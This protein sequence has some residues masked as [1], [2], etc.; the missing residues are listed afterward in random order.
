MP[1]HF[2]TENI[3]FKLPNPQ[4]IRRWISAVVEKEQ[5]KYNE[6]AYIFCDDAYLYTLNVDY[7]DHDTYTDIITFDYSNFPFI[8]GDLFISVERVRENAQNFSTDFQQELHRVMI[9]GILHL[10][11]YADKT[12]EEEKNMRAKEDFYLPLFI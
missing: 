12:P 6:I 2:Y 5:K 11:G 9:H 3:D 10:C 4:K 7:L 8:S 1:I